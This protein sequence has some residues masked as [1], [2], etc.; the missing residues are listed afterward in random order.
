LHVKTTSTVGDGLRALFAS[1]TR[2][3]LVI[4]T[5]LVGA[6]AAFGLAFFLSAEMRTFADVTPFAQLTVSV[7]TPFAAAV[8]TFDLRDRD[9]DYRSRTAE[10]LRTRWIAAGIY[11]LIMGVYVAVI[12]G[13]A[14]MVAQGS[15]PLADP[16]AGAVPTAIGSVLVQLIPVGVGCAAGLLVPR[17]FLAALS[18]IVVPISVTVL[19]GFL[20]PRGTADWLTPLG[21]AGHLVPGP[22][23]ILNWAQ[24]VITA[25]LWVVLPNVIGR[26]LLM[27][28]ASRV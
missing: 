27:R 24:L 15:Q 17:L 20:A 10:P 13:V 16:W 23:T 6:G 26:R 2:I 12:S 18:T 14:V 5:V 25:G 28:R 22:M 9:G 19:L 11:G 3:A 4:A 8:L 7:L 1:E 21:A